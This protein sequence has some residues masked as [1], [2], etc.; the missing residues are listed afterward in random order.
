MDCMP[1]EEFWTWKDESGVGLFKIFI[2]IFSLFALWT[3]LE[4]IIANK[5][6]LE[7]KR[8]CTFSGILILIYV[9]YLMMSFKA[10][11]ETFEVKWGKRNYQDITFQFKPFPEN[12]I[13]TS[14]DKYLSDRNCTDPHYSRNLNTPEDYKNYLNKLYFDFFDSGGTIKDIEES[15]SRYIGTKEAYDSYRNQGIEII[16]HKE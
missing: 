10:H 11:W 14:W 9:A 13:K 3:I 15:N 7:D 16:I 8:F 1:Y 5:C 12:P 2:L 6:G 4:I